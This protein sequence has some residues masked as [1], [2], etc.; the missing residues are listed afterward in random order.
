ML[1][2]KCTI[3]FEASLVFLRSVHMGY[4]RW[5]GLSES[6]RKSGYGLG[7]TFRYTDEDKPPLE[8]GFGPLPVRAAWQLTKK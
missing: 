4:M 7:I 5:H 2:V 1:F 6:C 3:A 8:S